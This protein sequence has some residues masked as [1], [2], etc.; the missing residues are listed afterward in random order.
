MVIA[1]G[2]A[3]LGLL[4]GGVAAASSPRHEVPSASAAG[5]LVI[6]TA[7]DLATADPGRMF[8]F[9]G[10]IVDRAIYSTLL[11]YSNCGARTTSPCPACSA[12]RAHDC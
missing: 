1:S 8:E 3:A 2:A 11:T 12:A 4:T 5:T 9:T 7:F 6:G 10:Q